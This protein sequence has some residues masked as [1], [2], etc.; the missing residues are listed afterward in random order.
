M[1][2]KEISHLA[3]RCLSGVP[4]SGIFSI[5]SLVFDIT[6]KLPITQSRGKSLATIIIIIV[7]NI[8][9]IKAINN[10][11]KSGVLRKKHHGDR[12]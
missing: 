4:G 10:I 3:F 1:S 12:I 6:E 8:Y 11:K 5:T 9:E 7:I 2:G